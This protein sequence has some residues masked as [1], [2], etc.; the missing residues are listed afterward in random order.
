MSLTS[1]V[2]IFLEGII[3]GSIV[4]HLDQYN[5]IDRSQHGFTKGKSCLTNLL[6]FFEVVTKD[7]DEG[8]SVDLIYLDFL[9]AFDKVPYERLFKK[10]V[11]HGI[12]GSIFNWVRNWLSKRRQRVCI[13]G[14]YSE[15]AEVTSGG[16]HGSV[17]RP[18]LFIIYINDLD[19]NIISKIDKFA[20]DSKLGKSVM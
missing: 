10:L 9:K 7:L 16:P 4:S 1:I 14:E 3:K 13:D 15:W 11:S 12:G 19:K 17:L 2:G 18:V 8:N 20:D 6:D 5:R